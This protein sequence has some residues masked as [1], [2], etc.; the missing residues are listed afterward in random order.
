[1]AKKGFKNENPAEI[2]YTNP[3]QRFTEPEAAPEGA[4]K[5]A[6]LHLSVYPQIKED[7]QAIAGARQISLMELVN[8]ILGDYAAAQADEIAM[9]KQLQDQI[10]QLRNKG[11]A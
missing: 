5:S 2:Q 10:A 8:Q 9:Y 4:T 3:A 6:R 7:L 1:M 11:R